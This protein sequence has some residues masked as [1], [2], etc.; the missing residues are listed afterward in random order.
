MDFLSW[1]VVLSTLATVAFAWGVFLSN[2]GRIPQKS[3]EY[4][5]LEDRIL[6]LMGQF[7]HMSAI[8]LNMLDKKIEEMRKLIKEANSLYG[9]LCVQE[10][11]LVDKTCEWDSNVE[12]E[13][14]DKEPESHESEH[15]EAPDSENN[16]SVERKILLLYQE[17]KTEQEIARSL[18][19]GV[20]EV[21]LILSLFRHRTD[22]Q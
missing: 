2:L 18:G 19:I 20:G 7:R 14:H 3:E 13:L 5:K 15:E 8:R 1:L 4:E 16:T 21:M 11:K 10:T 17:G 22:H 12:T 6:Q 9:K